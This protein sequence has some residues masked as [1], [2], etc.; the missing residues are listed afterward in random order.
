MP[1]ERPLKQKAPVGVAKQPPAVATGQT[2]GQM[3]KTRRQAIRLSLAQVEVDT[4][5]RGKFLTALEAGDY[6]KPPYDIYSR[7]FVQ[8]YAHH[9]G[10]NGAEGAAASAK[11][12]G[13]VVAGETKRPQLQQ[14]K[15]IVFTGKILT[16]L[17]GLAVVA[18]VL[19]YLLWQF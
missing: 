3:L 6:E 5:I 12:R 15:R 18:A 2:V 16:L 11:G 19:G 9:L 13:G 14:S 7:G 10:L 1:D 8:H 4:K 17:G